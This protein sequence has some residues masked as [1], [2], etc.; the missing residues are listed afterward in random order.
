MG[1]GLNWAVVQPTLRG[2][3]RSVRLSRPC[4]PGRRHPA[5]SYS[6]LTAALVLEVPHAYFLLYVLDSDLHAECELPG[7]S[8]C[9]LLSAAP[10]HLAWGLGHKEMTS[11]V[12]RCSRH[13]QLTSPDSSEHA[14]RVTGG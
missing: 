5:H 11:S 3:L 9:L 4:H 7:S 1:P 10:Q 2:Q 12:I 6:V 14:P 13:R 8:I